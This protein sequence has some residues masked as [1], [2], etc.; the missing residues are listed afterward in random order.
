[1]T[2]RTEWLHELW[3]DVLCHLP[4]GIA[5]VLL[6]MA[7]VFFAGYE[8]LISLGDGHLPFELLHHIHIFFAGVT[9]V[10]N[11]RRYSKSVVYA[12]LIGLVVPPIFCSVSDVIFPYLGGLV[13][14]GQMSFHLCLFESPLLLVGVALVGVTVGLL[15]SHHVPELLR[16][17]VRSHFLHQLVSALAALIYVASFGFGGWWHR[18]LATLVVLVVSVLVPCMTSDLVVPWFCARLTGRRIVGCE[19]CSCHGSIG[20]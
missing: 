9:A 14:G 11:F 10:V 1:M 4:Y 12:L 13:L 7:T 20:R 16:L 5:A 18:P 2:V 3:V 19:S 6:S 15:A 8:S 17:A